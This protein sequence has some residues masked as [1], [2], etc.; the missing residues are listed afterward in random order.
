MAYNG[1]NKRYFRF[2]VPNMELQHFNDN[3]CIITLYIPELTNIK[4]TR[5]YPTPA[6]PAWDRGPPQ[7]SCNA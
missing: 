3:S 5:R 6:G 7:S 4:D 2:G 1:T